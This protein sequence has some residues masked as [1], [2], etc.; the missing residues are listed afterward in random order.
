MKTISCLRTIRDFDRKVGAGRGARRGKR[1]LEG[2]EIGRLD[3]RGRQCCSVFWPSVHWIYWLVRNRSL[4]RLF[5]DR[6]LVSCW[7]VNYLCATYFFSLC[8]N[9]SSVDV[10]FACRRL[11]RSMFD[12]RWLISSCVP[13]ITFVGVRFAARLLGCCVYFGNLGQCTII[14]GEL[15]AVVN[16]KVWIKKI[17]G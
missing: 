10:H 9:W 3:E 14:A 2:S 1:G 5:D 16:M 15:A 11:R 17:N 13:L 12:D 7:C 4:E 8:T 6:W